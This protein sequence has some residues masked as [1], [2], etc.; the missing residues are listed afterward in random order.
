[1]IRNDSEPD[2]VDSGQQTLAELEASLQHVFDDIGNDI[3][4]ASILGNSFSIGK[5]QL[6]ELMS[7]NGQAYVFRALDSELDR[8]IVV[9]LYR[10]G[11]DKET[12]GRVLIEGR[13]MA[14]L[15]HPHVVR[16][17]TV[18]EHNETPFLV[19]EFIRGETLHEFANRVRPIPSQCIE[20][21]I[22]IASGLECTHEHG[23]LHLDLK[24]SN[25]MVTN[26]GV[27]KLIDFGLAQPLNDISPGDSSGT[28]SFMSPERASQQSDQVGEW[29]DVFGLGGLLYYL[30]MGQPPFQGDSKEEVIEL[31]K[32]CDVA[33]LSGAIPDEIRDLCLRSLHANPSKRFQNVSEFLETAN[34]IVQKKFNKWKVRIA[35]GVLACVVGV[36]AGAG[37]Y[38]SLPATNSTD[39]MSDVGKAEDNGN[40]QSRTFEIFNNPN[41]DLSNDFP[42]DVSLVRTDGTSFPEDDNGYLL[43]PPGIEIAVKFTTTQRC[44]GAV[45]AFNS[46]NDDVVESPL[47]LYPDPQLPGQ[48]VAVEFTATDEH[49]VTIG[50]SV[51]TTAG[52]I[53]YIF[54]TAVT[55]RWR[56]RDFDDG[57]QTMSQ[58][59]GVKRKDPNE[60]AV[61]LLIP[62][63]VSAK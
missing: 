24:P 50:E 6:R 43:V 14:R 1:M 17:H 7:C 32:R 57:E 53:D 33:P 61:E 13:A 40:D 58:L 46:E 8:D 26:T 9:K 4:A 45:Y 52:K 39:R 18:E 27:V 62:Y 41:L 16:C 20:L 30:L 36:V 29:T 12:K 10:Q 60:K 42:C 55:S 15:A 5:Y 49:Q 59:R 11:M 56:P 28:P 51:P 3:D 44:F 25:I 48:L 54:V 23:F 34:K 37:Y 2:N 31:A 35:V 47:L 19:T 38:Y 22:Q 21:M 63:R